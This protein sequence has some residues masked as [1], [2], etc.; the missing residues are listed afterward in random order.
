[1][2]DRASAIAR[3]VQEA[4]VVTGTAKR[5]KRTKKTGAAGEGANTRV[6]EAGE[7]LEKLEI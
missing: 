1:M 4:P 5:K 2:T 7:G 3:W 6:D